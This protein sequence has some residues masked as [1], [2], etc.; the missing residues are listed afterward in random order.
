MGWKR[1]EETILDE[2]VRKVWQFS[3]DQV[4]IGG[5]SWTANFDT[6]LQPVI[7]GLGCEGR[8]VSAELYKVLVYDT[9]GFFLAHRY[10]EKAGGMFVHADC[11]GIKSQDFDS[12]TH[13]FPQRVRRFQ[14]G[15]FVDLR[16]S[17][18]R[19]TATRG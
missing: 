3:P 8:A 10:T 16:S 12:S 17:G 18:C 4:K 2:S 15:R 14:G 5:K 6:I 13:V 7:A 11:P 9:G 1:P 19:E